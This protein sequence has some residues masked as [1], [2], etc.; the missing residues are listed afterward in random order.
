MPGRRS[1]ND[2]FR[3]TRRRGTD[4]LR[5][6]WIIRRHPNGSNPN[7]DPHPWNGR[8]CI[9][10]LPRTDC[11]RRHRSAPTI[12]FPPNRPSPRSMLCR[13]RRTGTPRPRC[14]SG[15]W[16]RPWKTPGNST[17]L[18][19]V[20]LSPTLRRHR[21]KISGN[22]PSRS[23]PSSAICDRWRRSGNRS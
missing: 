23:K 22:T 14:G 15:G 13:N 8:H 7:P 11:G 19:D 16:N 17:F 6:R 10:R 18:P 3:P 2:K 20:V 21:M 4:R 12:G 9:R 5:S 1:M